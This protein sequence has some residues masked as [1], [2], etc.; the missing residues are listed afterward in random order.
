[1]APSPFRGSA[2]TTPAKSSWKM[3]MSFMSE[4]GVQHPSGSLSP[5]FASDMGYVRSKCLRLKIMFK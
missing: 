2:V 1:M 3:K 4:L 5:C